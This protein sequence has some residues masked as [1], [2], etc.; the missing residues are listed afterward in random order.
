MSKSG[1]ERTG[2]RRLANPFDILVIAGGATNAL[3]VVLLVGY[4]LLHG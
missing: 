1:P 2:W 3:V 4:W